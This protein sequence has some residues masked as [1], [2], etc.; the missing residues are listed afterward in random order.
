MPATVYT[1]EESDQQRHALEQRV[2]KLE[3]GVPTSP[4]PAPPPPPPPPAPPPAGVKLSPSEFVAEIKLPNELV[5]DGVKDMTNGQKQYMWNAPA[6][7]SQA[8]GYTPAAVVMGANPRPY[9]SWFRPPA[10]FDKDWRYLLPWMVAFEAANHAAENVGIRLTAPIFETLGIGAS[11]WQT[12]LEEATASTWFAA[13][14]ADVIGD[15]GPK[16]QIRTVDGALEVKYTPKLPYVIHGLWGGFRQIDQHAIE[17]MYTQM[18]AQLV[19]WDPSEPDDRDKANLMLQVGADVYP[20]PT[21]FSVLQKRG[22]SIMPGVFISRQRRIGNEPRVFAMAN[23]DNVRQD[24]TN[25]P[26]RASMSVSRFLA[27]PPRSMR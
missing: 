13:S 4:P 6:Y 17:G 16:L 24:S 15:D 1:T 25:Q 5:A 27:V 21:S 18:I 20:E 14:K 2:A 3:Q 22:L 9:L 12:V 19:V 23:L 10:A 11:D 7:V 8:G 26:K